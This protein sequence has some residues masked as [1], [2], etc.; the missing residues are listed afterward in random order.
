MKLSEIEEN[1]ASI[2]ADPGPEYVYALLAAY[3]LPKHS[4]TRLRSGSYDKSVG[5]DT[6]CRAWSWNR[7]TYG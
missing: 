7:D 3:G 2:E 5:P 1:V 4:I 6:S